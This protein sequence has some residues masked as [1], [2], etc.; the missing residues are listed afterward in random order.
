SIP[1]SKKLLQNVAP[2]ELAGWLYLGAAAGC[3]PAVARTRRHRRIRVDSL[4]V[5]RLAW[6]IVFGGMAGPIL[7][8]L[9]LR[10]SRGGSVGLLLNF[11]M[12]ATAL[13]GAFLFR[14][15]LGR[16]GVVG[17]AFALC[18]GTLL[19][20]SG[21]RPGWTSGLLVLG[22]CVA[23]GFDNQLTSVIDGMSTW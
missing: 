19:S 23:W 14:E 16:A 8:L 9:A 4:T 17:V 21:G 1:A 7:V 20:L 22:A 6:A 12:V 11:E 2:L 15:R 13:V 18:A 5:R 3:L 10:S